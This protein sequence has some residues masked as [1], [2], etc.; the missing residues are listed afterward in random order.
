MDLRTN[1]RTTTGIEKIEKLGK[2]E[3]NEKIKFNIDGLI[4]SHNN[5][6]S[7]R[8]PTPTT[9]TS[10]LHHLHHHHLNNT[11]NGSGV[12][13]GTPPQTGISQLSSHPLPHSMLS[14]AAMSHMG[15][16][17]PFQTA[18]VNKLLG[19]YYEASG[20]A[21]AAALFRSP[22]HS[23]VIGGS[24]PKVATPVV[25]N[26][27]E[28][29]KRENPTIFAWEI[30]E[31]L[32]SEGVCT[33]GTAPSVSSINRIL[34][35]RAAERAAAEFA[36]NY[37]LAAAATAA[38]VHYPLA[39]HPHHPSAHQPHPYAG[40]NSGHAHQLYAAWAAAATAAALASH[41]HPHGQTGHFW[42]P[43]PLT[44]AALLQQQHNNSRDE[45]DNSSPRDDRDIDKDDI[46]HNNSNHSS[47]HSNSSSPNHSNQSAVLSQQQL[48]FDPHLT[49]DPNSSSAKFRR[50]RT[51]FSHQ[52]LEVLEEE[53]ERTHY[54]C[55][56][57]RER[58]AQITSLSEARV[59]VWFSN[60]RAKWRRHQ[61]MSHSNSSKYSMIGSRDSADSPTIDMDS[62]D[63]CASRDSFDTIS[64]DKH[65][66]LT[67]N[68]SSRSGTPHGSPSPTRRHVDNLTSVATSG[69][70]SLTIGGHNSAFK[71][72]K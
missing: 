9:T 10:P 15:P 54:P 22:N 34:R 67:S 11:N 37:Q 29:Y 13:N 12:G 38:S 56:T 30:R 28:Q 48:P 14:P 68:H 46:K 51:T 69:G 35:N 63:S 32:I 66:T 2:L 18:A 19:R 26:K 21:S 39:P 60:R 59:Q 64:S 25:V 3:N 33:N 40:S 16:F 6:G 27:I 43:T 20:G 44:H 72:I 8:E 5:S 52:Q 1:S 57:T 50:N 62:R 17:S 42:P 53:F 41:Q 70:A 58:L 45:L 36:R 47:N 7:T 65:H 24:K 49:F 23:T 55:V 4:A 71:K 61:R 31:R